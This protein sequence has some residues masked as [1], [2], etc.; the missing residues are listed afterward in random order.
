MWLTLPGP[1]RSASVIVSPGIGRLLSSFE[2]GSGLLDEVRAAT[3]GCGRSRP[4]GSGTPASC[5]RAAD[6]SQ[7]E[8]VIATKTSASRGVFIAAPPYHGPR[9]LPI[10][11]A[12]LLALVVLAAAAAP[13]YSPE[14]DRQLARSIY[15]ELVSAKTGYTTGE[16]TKAAEAMAKRLTDAGFPKDDVVVLGAAPHKGNLVARYRGTGKARPLLLL[17][18]LDVVEARPEDWSVDPFTLLEKDGYFYGR[19]TGDDKAQAAI[20]VA[21]LLRMRREGY[22]P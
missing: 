1:S 6:A 3:Y 13:T 19:G 9:R 8:D 16:T 2:S 12:M 18:H 7:L 4:K 5:A 17:A 22:R 10:E 14:A 21:S 15:D 20:W 11:S